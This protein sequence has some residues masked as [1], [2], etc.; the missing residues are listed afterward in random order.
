MIILCTSVNYNTKMSNISKVIDLLNKIGIIKLSIQ[1]LGE[2][3]LVSQLGNPFLFFERKQKNAFF[4]FFLSF[5][6]LKYF[7]GRER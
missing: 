3:M 5:F 1:L 6:M 7:Q 2:L 4:C